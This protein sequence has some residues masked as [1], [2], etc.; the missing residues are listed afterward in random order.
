LNK[1]ILR[2]Y[3]ALKFHYND[4]LMF[5]SILAPS[6]DVFYSSLIR[7]PPRMV[8]MGLAG[9]YSLGIAYES[10]WMA[11]IDRIAI[12]IL[13]PRVGYAGLGATMPLVQWY[14]AWTV[15][16]LATITAGTVFYLIEKIIGFFLSLYF[17]SK[18]LS[19]PNNDKIRLPTK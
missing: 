11:S 17:S 5:N 15:R 12:G 3:N 13:R 16:I 10:G 18:Q 9:F 14:A 8:V 2:C 1:K 4:K 19:H 6:T 7:W